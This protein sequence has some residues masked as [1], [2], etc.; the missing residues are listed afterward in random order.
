M[1]ALIAAL[2]MLIN[3]PILTDL[4]LKLN[5]V[6]ITLGKGRFDNVDP[7]VVISSVDLCMLGG[8]K[9]CHQMNLL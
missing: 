4:I 6:M 2:T 5:K 3:A 9:L 7:T 1:L 8:A